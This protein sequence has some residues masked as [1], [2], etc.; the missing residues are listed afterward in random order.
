[1][2]SIGVIDTACRER[3]R[4]NGREVDASCRKRCFCAGRRGDEL[5]AH[6]PS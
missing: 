1:M 2:Q 4:D 5:Q 6:R 3:H